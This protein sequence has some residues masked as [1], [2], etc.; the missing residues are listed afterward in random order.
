M[1]ND[2]VEALVREGKTAAA[3]WRLATGNEGIHGGVSSVFL[4]NLGVPLA[5]E[6][7]ENCAGNSTHD[8]KTD[9]NTNGNSDR[10]GR[11]TL[12]LRIA[13]SSGRVYVSSQSFR[14]NA[15]R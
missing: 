4:L 7:K 3:R 15:T 12:L 10:V 13:G 5:A 11:A 8:Q 2:G 9:D 6:Y 1:G 14:P